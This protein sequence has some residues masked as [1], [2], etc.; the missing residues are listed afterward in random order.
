MPSLHS[1]RWLSGPLRWLSGPPSV[2]CY[3][4][5]L[6]TYKVTP[7]LSSK[8]LMCC[9]NSTNWS[10]SWYT[11]PRTTRHHRLTSPVA[12]PGPP[13]SFLQSSS[14]PLSCLLQSHTDSCLQSQLYHD[15]HHHLPFLI[16]LH[17]LT[18]YTH[19]NTLIRPNLVDIYDQSDRSHQGRDNPPRAT[20]LK[21]EKLMI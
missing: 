12:P 5:D 9:S 15:H 10:A 20:I 17:H 2:K 11:C 4:S 3:W 19:T 1:L 8:P 6:F 14:S 7:R 16:T 21:W 18:Y 13:R